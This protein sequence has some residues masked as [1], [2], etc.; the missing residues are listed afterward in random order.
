MAVVPHIE[1]VGV[2]KVDL[3]ISLAML[4]RADARRRNRQLRRQRWREINRPPILARLDQPLGQ[5]AADDRKGPA[6]AIGTA[7]MLGSQHAV[8][9]TGSRQRSEVRSTFRPDHAVLE[10]RVVS[11]FRE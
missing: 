4:S 1:V 10:A 5:F 3:Q 2:E 9:G 11:W 8:E 6:L 7:L